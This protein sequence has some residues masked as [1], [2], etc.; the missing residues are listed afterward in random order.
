MR[1]LAVHS[2]FHLQAAVVC[3]DDLVAEPGSNH[4]VGVD[5]FVFQ[6]PGW[7]HFTTKLFVVG[8]QQLHA[9]MR[10]LGD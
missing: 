4:Q 10:G 7:T 1:H 9:A 3:G 2:N 5:D 6:Q 8:E